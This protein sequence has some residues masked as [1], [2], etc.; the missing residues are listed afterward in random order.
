M[1]VA[2]FLFSLVLFVGSFLM[3]AYAGTVG[4]IG[5]G[6]MFLGGILLVSAAFAI[7]FH[8]LEKFD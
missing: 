5:A 4:G 2:V 7:P 3:F 6:A 1:K 8:L